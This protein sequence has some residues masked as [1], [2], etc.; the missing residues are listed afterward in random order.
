MDSILIMLYVLGIVLLD[1]SLQLLLVVGSMHH[2]G[3]LIQ[4]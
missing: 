1:Q 3:V 2:L 4:V